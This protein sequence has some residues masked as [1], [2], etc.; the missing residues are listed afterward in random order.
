MSRHWKERYDSS[1]HRNRM[2]GEG[3][4]TEQSRDAAIDP[5]WVYFVNVC[6]FTF[7]FH[8]LQQ[9]ETCFNYYSRRIQPSSRVPQCELE[10]DHW[11]M[12]RWY[13]QLPQEL[14]SEPKRRKVLKALRNAHSDFS[15][16]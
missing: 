3:C 10:G 14:Q 11:E 7:E 6:S 9:I 13:E 8:S 5:R 1:R 12:Q 15:Q 16:D 2:Y 4:E